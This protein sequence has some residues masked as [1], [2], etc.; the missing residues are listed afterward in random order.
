MGVMLK[1]IQRAESQQHLMVDPLSECD[2]VKDAFYSLVMG[3]LIG[4]VGCPLLEG[5]IFLDLEAEALEEGLEQKKLHTYTEA[6]TDGLL[7]FNH[8]SIVD[9]TLEE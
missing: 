3:Q 5:T 1:D 4:L 8:D 7:R 6:D 2:C 9:L